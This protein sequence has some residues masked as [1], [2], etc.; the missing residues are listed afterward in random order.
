MAQMGRPGLSAAKKRELWQRWKDGASLSDIA[1]ALRKQP[2]SIH[3]VVAA[4]GG[5]VPAERRRSCRTLS[6]RER[7][8]ISRNLA[9]GQSVRQ[10]A[11]VIQRAPRCARLGLRPPRGAMAF[12][13]CGT[14]REPGVAQRCLSR[15]RA[16]ARACARTARLR[17]L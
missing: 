7:E 13:V 15:G 17:R 16:V 6:L 1:R 9:A 8:E 10:I 12:T 11:A 3:G 14:P 5:F 2:G 4:N